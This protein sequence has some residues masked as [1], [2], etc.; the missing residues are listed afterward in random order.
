MSLQL[1][2]AKQAVL[3][4]TQVL[5]WF[6]IWKFCTGGKVVKHCKHQNVNDVDSNVIIWN[7]NVVIA[8]WELRLINITL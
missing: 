6:Y 3:H 2:L 1:Y 5:C 8:W 4:K 7:R